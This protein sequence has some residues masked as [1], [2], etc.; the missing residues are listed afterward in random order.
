MDDNT[1]DH[2]IEGNDPDEAL[3]SLV[4]DAVL[5]LARKP[6]PHRLTAMQMAGLADEH[7]TTAQ[8]A[9]AYGLSRRQIRAAEQGALYYLAWSHPELLAELRSSRRFL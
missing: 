1:A 7:P 2:D 9:R 8:I 4:A 6:G 5:E 3:A